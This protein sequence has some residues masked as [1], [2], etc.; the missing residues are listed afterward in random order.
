M[1]DLN[2]PGSSSISTPSAAPPQ[3]P[4]Q[5]KISSALSNLNRSAVTSASGSSYKDSV[6][7]N[8]ST[9]SAAGSSMKSS[10]G[11]EDSNRRAYNTDK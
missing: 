10:S 7:S 5:S 2:F 3:P 8:G 9:S 11:Y 6:S 1:I 4:G